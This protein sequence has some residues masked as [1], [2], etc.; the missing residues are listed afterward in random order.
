MFNAGEE[1]QANRR[2]KL[3]WVW[4]NRKKISQII[5]DYI[6]LPFFLLFILWWQVRMRVNSMAY[7]LGFKEDEEDMKRYMKKRTLGK[8]PKET[9]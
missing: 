1:D 8:L 6:Y 9:V 2:Q 3:G 5:N 4:R 7:S